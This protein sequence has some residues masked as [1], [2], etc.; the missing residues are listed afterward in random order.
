L[1]SPNALI[2]R[3][4][5]GFAISTDSRWHQDSI[6]RVSC[7]V[8]AVHFHDGSVWKAGANPP[9]GAASPIISAAPIDSLFNQYNS[10]GLFEFKSKNYDMALA[11]F[12]KARALLSEGHATAHAQAVIASNLGSTYALTGQIDK[13]IELA[14]EVQRLDPSVTSVQSEIANYYKEQAEANVKAGDRAAALAAL[15]RG[16]VAAPNLRFFFY[17][18]SAVLLA[19]AKMPDWKK[20]LV[21]ADKAL[22]IAPTDAR[23]NY[24]AGLAT[25]NSGGDKKEAL[26]YLIRA[27]TAASTG[28]DVNLKQQIEDA[29]KQIGVAENPDSR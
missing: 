7:S 3:M 18:Q 14:Q 28:M 17:S 24:L 8:T 10:R 4:K 1:F 11:D 27:Q 13:A 23:S 20:V 29:I 9:V 5:E 15:E 16:A 2:D 12:E 26:S 25:A 21:E 19:N 6:S 22:A